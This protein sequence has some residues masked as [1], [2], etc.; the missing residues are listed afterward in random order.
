MNSSPRFAQPRRL[1]GTALGLLTLVIA[2]A[3]VF[4]GGAGA[5]EIRQSL[6]SA[7]E[8]APQAPK[9]AELVAS[10]RLHLDLGAVPQVA[11]APVDTNALLA[12]DELRARTASDKRLRYGVGRAIKAELADGRWQ[13]LAGGARLWAVDVVS[14]GAV[15]LRLHLPVERF[16]AGAELAVYPAE[17]DLTAAAGFGAGE[18]PNIAV[19]RSKEDLARR[20]FWTGTIAGDRARVEL[21]LP[22]SLV[23][24]GA[25]PPIAID[26]VRHLYRDPVASS[27][28]GLDKDAG[29]CHN[30]VTC[31]PAW[32]NIAKASAG[33]GWISGADDLWCS[34]TLID[35]E[36]HDKTPYLLTAH[37]CLATQSEAESLEVFWKYQTSTCG[38][39]PP[40]LTSVPRS[41][42]TTLLKTGTTSDFTLLMIEGTLPSGLF[43]AGWT[44]ASVANGTDSTA[45]HHP[46][47][48]F[49]R[50]SF[51]DKA[52]NPSC[53]G[54][55]LAAGSHVR[56]DWTDGPTEPGSSGSGIFRNDTQQLYGQLH[57]G[58]SA[59]GNET[60]DSYGAFSSTHPNIST[61]LSAGTDD[62]HENN[63][64]C[65]AAKDLGFLPIFWPLRIVKST[66]SDWYKATV[67]LLDSVTL[68]LAFEHDFG[69]IDVQAFTSCSGLV[70]TSS[71]STSDSETITFTN[72]SAPTQ[73][74]FFHVYLYSDTR[75]SYNLFWQP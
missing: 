64:S 32:A 59:C 1:G 52:A 42:V 9:A 50:I 20:G 28:Q 46:S 43:W 16:P 72:L 56:V 67:S 53:L 35:A 15:G 38:G 4:G 17:R 7:E 51:G 3:P 8:R 55:T 37:H 71:Q 13:E 57:C 68:T 63:D 70:V 61:E 33:I 58:P 29:P 66:D 5:A 45:I 18:D 23:R 31:F 6:G 54:A 60:F 74:V 36:N 11:L 12:E 22:A 10:A 27:G 41:A 75:N 40:A 39:A 73:T 65:A 62:S 19:F 48:D 30:D 24:R 44:S 21:Y 25:S 47:G 26:G 34:A 2:S 49:K 14:P 69:D